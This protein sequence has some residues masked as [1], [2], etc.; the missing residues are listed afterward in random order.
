MIMKKQEHIHI[1]VSRTEKQLMKK[2]AQ[3]EDRK[4][5]SFIRFNVLAICRKAFNQKD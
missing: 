5:S 3:K 1:R 4:L 2:A